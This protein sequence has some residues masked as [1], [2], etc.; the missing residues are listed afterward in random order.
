MV[1]EFY[2]WVRVGGEE[3]SRRE[4]ELRPGELVFPR[5]PKPSLELVP[6]F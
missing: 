1:L 2:G 4:G 6:G 5:N 3:N